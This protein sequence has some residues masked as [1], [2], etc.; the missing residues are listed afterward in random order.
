[1]KDSPFIHLFKVATNCFFYDV[2]KN[3]ILKINEKVYKYLNGEERNYDKV[4]HEIEQLKERGYLSQKRILEIQHPMTHLISDY[5]D[6]KMQMISLQVTQNCNLRCGYCIYGG[7]YNT[8]KHSEKV[9]SLDTAKKAIDFFIAHSSESDRIGIAFYGGEPLLN[10]P[11]IREIVQYVHHE[12]PGKEY[13]FTITTNGTA[14]TEEILQCLEQNRFG[15]MISLDGDKK[16]HDM[17]RKFK[18]SEKGSFDVVIKN[19]EHIKNNYPRIFE[20]IAFSVVLSVASDFMGCSEF[21]TKLNIAEEAALVVTNVSDRY[22]DESDNIQEYNENNAIFQRY[23]LFKCLLIFSGRLDEKD[24]SNM[25]KRFY[26]QIKNTYNKLYV[27]QNGVAEID[28]PAGSCIPGVFRLFVNVDGNFYPCEKISEHSKVCRLGD[29]DN[30]FD[31][32]NVEAGLNVGK[33]GEQL[34]NNCWAY[35]YCKLCVMQVDDIDK[36]SVEKKIVF[37]KNVKKEVDMMMREYAFINQFKQL[38]NDSISK[39]GTS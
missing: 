31:M 6:N 22:K 1:M 36:F 10:F 3:N 12:Y 19:L 34:C 26:L 13:Y 11:L 5:L 25:V 21:F 32:Q 7:D 15:V 23:E 28:H 20:Q 16:T 30:G 17:N 35:R 37:C 27:T 29:L 18:N 8:R 9:M 39:E 33:V 24:C 4:V 14:F 38:G 2:N